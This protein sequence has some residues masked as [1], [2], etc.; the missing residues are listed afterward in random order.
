MTQHRKHTYYAVIAED[1]G[2]PYLVCDGGRVIFPT[3]LKAIDV[4]K[5]WAKR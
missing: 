2:G 3:K 5:Q 1:Q 4:R